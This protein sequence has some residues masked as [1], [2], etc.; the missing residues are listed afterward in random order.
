MSCLQ[1]AKAI[2]AAGATIINTGIGWH[3]GEI[4]FVLT[5]LLIITST[6]TNLEFISYY[7]HESQRLPLASRAVASL[8]SLRS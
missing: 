4:P 7:Q 5:A 8:G 3:E 2:E 6:T 1:L